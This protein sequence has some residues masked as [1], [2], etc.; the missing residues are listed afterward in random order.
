VIA[1]LQRLFKRGPKPLPKPLPMVSPDNLSCDQGL[2]IQFAAHRCARFGAH[3]MV[4][5]SAEDVAAICRATLTYLDQES[6]RTLTM[7]KD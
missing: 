1:R 6:Q 7:V 5:G 2:V 3:V 4:L